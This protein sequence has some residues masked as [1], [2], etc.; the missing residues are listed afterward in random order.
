MSKKPEK[1]QSGKVNYIWVLA[2]VYLIYLA[3]KL[4]RGA[5]AGE[6]PVPAIGI[7]AG[8]LFV[9]VGAFLLHHEWKAYKYG[10]E[11]MDDPSSWNDEEEDEELAQ[12]M[13]SS[14]EL[15]EASEEDAE[16]VP[17]EEA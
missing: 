9:I 1:K 2:G 16:D 7:A 11:H 4:F 3:Y 15:A 8:V 13:E 17:E 5:M 10:M 12:L 6:A 14:K